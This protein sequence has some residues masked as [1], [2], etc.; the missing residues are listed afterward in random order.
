ISIYLSYYA[1]K[2]KFDIIEFHDYGGDFTYFIGKTPKVVRCHGT[3]VVLHQ[4]MGYYKRQ[5]DAFF[6]YQFF[7]RFNKNIVAVSKTSAEMTQRAFQLKSLP[8]VIYNG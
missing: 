5:P 6:E 8:K 1:L 2:N 7:K 3:A 4:F